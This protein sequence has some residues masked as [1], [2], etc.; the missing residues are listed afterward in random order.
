[1]FDCF[2]EAEEFGFEFRE[3]QPLRVVSY[4]DGKEV[5]RYVPLI[6]PQLWVK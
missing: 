6:A 5:E 2:F 4:G 3:R 1:M